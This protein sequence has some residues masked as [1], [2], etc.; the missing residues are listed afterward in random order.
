MIAQ[1]MIVGDNEIATLAVR[2]QVCTGIPPYGSASSVFYPLM[3]VVDMPCMKV[4]WARK[5]KTTIGSVNSAA[6]A[7]S[8]HEIAPYELTNRSSPY[9]NGNFSGSFKYNKGPPKSFQVVTN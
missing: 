1:S 5:N 2:R 3:P 6:A 7:N 8:K 9:A 4:F